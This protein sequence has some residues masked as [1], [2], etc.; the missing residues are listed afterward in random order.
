M[1]WWGWGG[2]AQHSLLLFVAPSIWSGH[3]FAAKHTVTNVMC[4]GGVWTAPQTLLYEL[5][6]GAAPQKTE[7]CEVPL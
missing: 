3:P 2:T 1:A 5:Y 6:H 7:V 4:K